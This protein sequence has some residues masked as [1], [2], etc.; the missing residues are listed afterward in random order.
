MW[1]KMDANKIL[2]MDSNEQKKTMTDAFTG[3]L[4]ED[5]NEMTN[6]LYSLLKDVQKNGTDEEYVKLCKT[7]ISIA[8]SLDEK[9]LKSFMEARMN[10]NKKLD[11]AGQSR[12]MKN[13]MKA[14]EG[15]PFKDKIMSAIGSK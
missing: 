5:Q 7:N 10:A 2:K 12:D 1:I 13:L 4:K 9:T 11:S 3:M 8:G 14:M 6:Q 15:S